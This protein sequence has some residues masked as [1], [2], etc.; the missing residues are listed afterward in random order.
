MT[1][2]GKGVY[3]WTLRVLAVILM[4]LLLVTFITMISAIV[5]CV[6]GG[7]S[8]GSVDPQGFVHWIM[9]LIG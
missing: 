8:P 4:A 3:L 6:I 5:Y 9:S 7:I 2:I 1:R